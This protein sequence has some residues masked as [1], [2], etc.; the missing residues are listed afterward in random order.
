MYLWRLAAVTEGRPF[1]GCRSDVRDW[2]YVIS[3]NRLPNRYCWNRLFPQTNAN[4]SYSIVSTSFPCQPMS[5]MQRLWVSLLQAHCVTTPP[6]VHMCWHHKTTPVIGLGKWV[7]T[8]SEAI[9]VLTSSKAVELSVVQFHLACFR[10][11]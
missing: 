8:S 6:P 4:A 3:V 7:S 9:N 1:S 2:W 5:V 10:S 11:N